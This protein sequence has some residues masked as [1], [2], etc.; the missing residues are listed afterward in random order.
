MSKP[1]KKLRLWLIISIGFVPLAYGAKFAYALYQN[2]S[3]GTFGD[4]FGAANAL[5]SG[6][7]LM[8]LVYAVLL[9]RDELE[10]IKQERDST[11]EL[12]SG[13]E[14]INALQEAA[15]KRQIF[16][17]SFNA[18]LKLAVDELSRVSA[19][20]AIN[21]RTAPSS[22]RYASNR[23]QELLSV[24][25]AGKELNSDWDNSRQKTYEI[26]FCFNLI[27]HLATM[28]DQSTPEAIMQKPL[29]RLIT[30]MLNQDLAY[31]VAWFA[32]ENRLQGGK[33]RN[34]EQFMRAYNVV[35]MLPESDRALLHSAMSRLES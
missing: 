30:S 35:H 13:Q 33:M 7:A 20:P 12:L 25:A 2:Q 34:I 29:Q 23:S 21:G 15:L 6:I 17:Q 8:M 27:I 19:V 31:C 11:R 32:I 16:D 10:I 5:F 1:M 28:I 3:G 24:V 18:L 22:L 4:T 14:R 26:F 9:Q